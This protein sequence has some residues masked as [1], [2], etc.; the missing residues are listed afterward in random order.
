MRVAI[1]VLTVVVA[2][3]GCRSADASDRQPVDLRSLLDEVDRASPQLLALRARAD[4]AEYVAPQKDVLPDPKL[5]VSYTNDG[6]SSFTLGSSEFANLTVGWEQEVTPRGVR[7]SAAAVANAQAGARRD[8]TA[9]VR[10]RLRARVITLYAEL[11]RLDRTQALLAETR[12]LLGTTADGAQARY[13]SGEGLQEGLI[14]AQ[15]AV[16]RAD[17]DLE[18]LGLSRRQVEI[19][20]G[21]VLG[22]IEDPA[23]GPALEL[24][25]V[26]G[27]IDEEQLAVTAAATSPEV[28]ESAARERT[29]EAQLDD[30]RVQVKPTY[31]WIAAYQY[32][33]ALDPMVIGGFSVRLPV[34]K[35]R[36]QERAIAAASIERTAAEHEREEAE[37]A[38]RAEARELA[39]AVASIDVRLRLYRDA[40]VPQS[41]AAYESANAAFAS[42]R[43]EMFLV[44]DDFARWIGARREELS[45]SAQRIGTIASL[46]A[47]SGARLLEPSRPEETP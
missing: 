5:S 15:S 25:T 21:T 32:R 18:E 2:A 1:V 9:S 7:E 27:T 44:L 11:W 31:S 45:L 47:V 29:A 42:G 33:G 38:A 23:F 14:R 40:I 12:A 46:E 39:A 43:A 34:W 24:P 37:L 41:A 8:S 26:S 4:A 35:D 13:E 36:K 22:R 30:A 19:A 17:V 10:A 6:L 3:C 20:L 16:R 28:L